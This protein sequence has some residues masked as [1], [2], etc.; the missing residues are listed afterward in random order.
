VPGL[1]RI[2]PVRP[3]PS[4]GQWSAIMLPTM[5]MGASPRLE[6]V[7]RAGHIN[8]I[9][10]M[11]TGAP[12]DSELAL[13]GTAAA[14]ALKKRS[15]SVPASKLKAAARA[16][17]LTTNGSGGNDPTQDAG[18]PPVLPARAMTLP[19]VVDNKGYTILSGPAPGKKALVNDDGKQLFGKSNPMVEDLVNTYKD[20][21]EERRDQLARA[22]RDA[23]ECAQRR[24]QAVSDYQQEQE[25]AA[26][27]AIKK[28]Q[29]ELAEKEAMIDDMQNQSNE[30]LKQLQ[31]AKDSGSASSEEVERLLATIA[32]LTIAR[33]SF[34]KQ[35]EQKVESCNEERDVAA[36]EAEAAVDATASEWEKKL[37]EANAE[38]AQKAL[39]LT[40][41]RD[42]CNDKLGKALADL[43]SEVKA[44]NALEKIKEEE[45][46]KFHDAAQAACAALNKYMDNKDERV[47]KKML[48]FV[49]SAPA[50]AGA[51]NVQDAKV[52][53]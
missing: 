21:T 42:E 11:Y 48:N 6:A 15:N 2:S 23:E 19:A 44:H 50:S 18:A 8:R 14:D 34:E 25:A 53:V 40:T 45:E 9:N 39:D 43:E 7:L 29:E 24:R 36:R 47:R 3:A 49:T 4:K 16:A 13:K 22:R 35:L 52:C 37:A 32:T 46:D 28:L 27:A 31:D 26:D 17:L 1:V 20:K 12:G 5:P 38:A 30:A 10:A 51:N 33:D 41:E